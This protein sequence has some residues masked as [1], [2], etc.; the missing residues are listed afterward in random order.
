MK[1]RRTCFSVIAT[2]FPVRAF[3]RASAR[4]YIIYTCGNKNKPLP[5]AC[6]RVMVARERRKNI[7][8]MRN[9]HLGI[10]QS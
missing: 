8:D 5:A 1:P 2:F 9:H 4:S 3:E 7:D 10:Y 6:A